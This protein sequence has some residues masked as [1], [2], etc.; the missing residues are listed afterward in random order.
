MI[1]PSNDIRQQLR[2]KSFTSDCLNVDLAGFYKSNRQ[3]R[4]FGKKRAKQE[5]QLLLNRK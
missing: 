1:K 3:S 2:F 5:Q 4:R